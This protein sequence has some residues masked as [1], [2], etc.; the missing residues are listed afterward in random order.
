VDAVPD[1]TEV[2]D[3]AKAVADTS[4]ANNDKNLCV[5]AS[6]S[7]LCQKHHQIS[8]QKIKYVTI[9]PLVKKWLEALAFG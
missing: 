7:C 8:Q 3:R 6:A 9:I 2:V 1:E 5:Q 4:G